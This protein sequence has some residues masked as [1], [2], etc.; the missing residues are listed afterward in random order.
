MKSKMKPELQIA[1]GGYSE[2]EIKDILAAFRTAKYQVNRFYK[3]SLTEVSLAEA[4][5]TIMVSG[6][7]PLFLKDFAKRGKN[8]LAKFFPP[9]KT[10]KK[11]FVHVAIEEQ[12]G[13]KSTTIIAKNV[14]ELH[15]EIK[16]QSEQ[17]EN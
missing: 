10:G 6:V 3:V 1:F 8:I 16:R 2:E 9:T 7:I 14:Q 17:S 15:L 13:E 11:S 12:K 4:I 5:V